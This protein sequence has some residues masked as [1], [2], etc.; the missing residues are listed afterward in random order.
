MHNERVIETVNSNVK[1]T[2]ARLS[3]AE[4]TEV[5]RPYQIKYNCFCEFYETASAQLFTGNMMD[6]LHTDIQRSNNIPWEC[7]AFM[8]C[9][10]SA[11]SPLARLA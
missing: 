1:K 4:S 10:F 3:Y 7:S 8:I 2:K 6:C 11:S 5:D 9:H